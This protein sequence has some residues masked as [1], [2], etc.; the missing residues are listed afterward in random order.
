MWWTLPNPRY[1]IASLILFA[2]DDS[3][4]K[5]FL[6]VLYVIPVAQAPSGGPMTSPASIWPPLGTQDLWKSSGVH[7]SIY[8][9]G[10]RLRHARGYGP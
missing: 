2:W 4:I 7:L 6:A 10:Q 8:G 1:G 9:S 3:G 5:F